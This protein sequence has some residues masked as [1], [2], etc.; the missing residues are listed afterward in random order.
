MNANK[1]LVRGSSAAPT[2]SARVE[3][4]EQRRLMSIAIPA[5]TQTNLVS[6]IPAIPAARNDA[7]LLNPWG[8]AITPAGN[9]WV[10][11]N[12]SGFST[13]YDQAGNP[14]PVSVVVPPP[15]GG[16]SS[17][18]TGIVANTGKGFAVSRNGI[19]H[20]SSFIFSTEDGT[21]SGYSPA[22]DANNAVLAVDH[23]T[24]G[25]VFKALALIGSGKGARI[26]ATDFHGGQ[27][28][29]FDSSFR[30]ITMKPG[31][32]SDP[33]IP[34][35]FA[36]FGIQNIHGDLYVTYAMQDDARHDPVA[37]AGNGF[38]DVFTATGKLLRRV[39]AGGTLNS[40]WAVDI[41][42]A[43]FGK[44]SGDLLIGNFD[45]GRINVFDHH[46]RFVT[47]LADSTGTPLTIGGLWALTN[48]VKQA[49]HAIFFAGGTNEEADGLFGMLTPAT[50]PALAAHSSGSATSFPY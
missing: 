1:E 35:N 30:Q 26:F 43:G 22:V 11:D 13:V 23:S 37:G 48:G 3:Q 31:S 50:S 18:P 41:A 9:V 44:L 49:R 8:I 32:F 39:A 45:D 29:V 47:Q 16:T 19:T 5:I 12:N 38:V 28:E 4:L 34:A 46:N 27:V 40:P 6:D 14:S 42:P 2:S 24:A 20:S 25:D 21:I 7:K 36:P 17:T 10:A 15:A 33:Q